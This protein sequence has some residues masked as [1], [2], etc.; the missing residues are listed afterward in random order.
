MLL[1]LLYNNA[2]DSSADLGSTKWEPA[3]KKEERVEGK[4]CP[5][6]QGKLCG[7]EGRPEGP[8]LL[9]WGHFLKRRQ[10]KTVSI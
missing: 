10:T 3:G 2:P 6:P 9:A 7:K 1:C 5:Q 8:V 4:P